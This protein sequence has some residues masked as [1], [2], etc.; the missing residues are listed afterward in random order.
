[1]LGEEPVDVERLFRVI[2]FVHAVE[3]EG[4]P[5][6]SRLSACNDRERHDPGV[7]GYRGSNGRAALDHT[8][9]TDRPQS[10]GIGP[11]H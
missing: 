3:T 9:T 6:E 11:V 2:Q 1:V 7:R 8:R 4:R 10:P 5:T